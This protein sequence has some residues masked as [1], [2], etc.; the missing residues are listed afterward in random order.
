MTSFFRDPE[1][2]RVLG[3]EVIP[4]VLQSTAETPG[5]RIGARGVRRARS[6]T[7]S[8]CSWPSISASGPATNVI[9]IYGTDVD[10]EALA[11]ARHGPYRLEEVKDVPAE[12]VD[13]H[14]TREGQIYRFRRDLWR[15]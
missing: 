1:A 9:K 13:R 3:A 5:L 4:R 10:E 8:P 6:P 14:F 12:I 11:A 15:W 2:W 7:R